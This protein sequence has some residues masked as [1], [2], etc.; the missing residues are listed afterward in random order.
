MPQVIQVQD[1]IAVTTHQQGLTAAAEDRPAFQ[2]RK[3]P[4]SQIDMHDHHRGQPG[5]IRRLQRYQIIKQDPIVFIPIRLKPDNA[6]GLS[7][8]TGRIQHGCDQL[9]GRIFG[10]P[11]LG[12]VATQQ[13][14]IV[15]PLRVT[16]LLQ[17]DKQSVVAGLIAF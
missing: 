12:V 3:Q 10:T 1:L 9:R 16:Q 6:A 2:N 15:N 17:P 5:A 7:G 13:T 14:S 4:I 8:F 11:D